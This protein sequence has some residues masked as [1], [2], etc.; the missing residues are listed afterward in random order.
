[1]R[2][3]LDEDNILSEP[4]LSCDKPYT[5]DIWWEWCCDVKR[6]IHSKEY[7]IAEKKLKENKQ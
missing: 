3:L 5:E 2:P 1:M 6:C 4:C 7:E